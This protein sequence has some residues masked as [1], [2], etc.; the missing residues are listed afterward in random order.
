MTEKASAM[1]AATLGAGMVMLYGGILVSQGDVWL[2]AIPFVLPLVTGLT[3]LPAVC[4]AFGSVI[5]GS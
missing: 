4:L 2:P 1:A 5:G 3:R